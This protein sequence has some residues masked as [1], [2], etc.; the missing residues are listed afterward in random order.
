MGGLHYCF[1]VKRQPQPFA[2]WVNDMN[3]FPTCYNLKNSNQK[4]STKKQSRDFLSI[5]LF[6][7]LCHGKQRFALGQQRREG[8]QK[9]LVSVSAQLPLKEL[10]L[11]CLLKS[12]SWWALL[13]THLCL[14][15]TVV[16]LG[17]KFLRFTLPRGKSASPVSQISLRD[18]T[19]LFLLPYPD[20]N[21]V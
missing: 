11:L 15:Q 17:I 16:E 2:F 9:D 6:L 1:W 13:K 7:S 10:S 12:A 4:N 8:L 14:R 5:S 20:Y 3:S 18:S 19:L 21:S